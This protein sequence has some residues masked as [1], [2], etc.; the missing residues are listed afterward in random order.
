MAAALGVQVAQALVLAT[1]VQVFFNA[2]GY[3]ALG[4]S[5][6]GSL[7][8]LLVCICLFWIL[9]RIPFWAKDLAFSGPPRDRHPDRAQLRPRPHP[10]RRP[11]TRPGRAPA[12]A[13]AGRHRARRP[14][15][16][17][18]D[19]PAADDPRRSRADRLRPLRAERVA[20]AGA[21]RRW[22]SPRLLSRLGC[23]WRLA[24]RDG[25]PGD[26]FALAA[27]RFLIQPRLR[28]LAPEG[29]PAPLPGAPPRQALRALDLPVAAVLASGLVDLSH[30]GFCRLLRASATGFALRSDEE[31]QALVEA[32]GRFLNG[33]TDPVEIVVRSEPVDL[34]SWA[35]R[36]EHTLPAA[37]APSLRAAAV[38]H[39]RFVAEL[40]SQAEVRRRE[41]VLVL[42]S[43]RSDREEAHGELERAAGETIDLLQA[44]GVELHPLT[45][46]ETALLLARTLDPPGPPRGA[47]LA[48]WCSRC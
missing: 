35:D 32:F 34:N 12:G 19:R 33:L 5:V 26:R 9:V 14:D 25:L 20:A 30:G 24:R 3:A 29:L 37:S 10:Q 18:A 8:D 11:M 48:E 17:R 42:R 15:R 1:A 27:A 22:R 13:T 43:S 6:S 44:A 21:G 16:L 40:G 7:I 23:C 47:R 38:A 46:K 36:L 4:L 39:A 2:G 31:Q 45:G 41:I 28:L